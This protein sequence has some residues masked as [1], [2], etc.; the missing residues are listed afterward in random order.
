MQLVASVIGLVL[1][2]LLMVQEVVHRRQLQ[3]SFMDGFR[4][5]KQYADELLKKEND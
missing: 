5:G 3:D 1:I 2:A 4:Y